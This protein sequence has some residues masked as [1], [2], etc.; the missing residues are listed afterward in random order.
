ASVSVSWSY[1]SAI[2]SLLL[3]AS[4]RERV[5]DRLDD[6]CLIDSLLDS[7]VR[8][9]VVVESPDPVEFEQRPAALDVRCDRLLRVITVDHNQ[10]E[11]PVA[12]SWAHRSAR[13]DG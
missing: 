11:V 10:I 8:N 4:N 3:R 7:E 9:R 1:T 13:T 5:D 2:N 12:N 6:E